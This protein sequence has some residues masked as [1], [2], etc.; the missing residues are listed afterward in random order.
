MADAWDE[1]TDC[2]SPLMVVNHV[3][4]PYEEKK[5]KTA[6]KEN[7]KPVS[8]KLS[9]SLISNEWSGNPSEEQGS[10]DDRTLTPSVWSNLDGVAI[11]FAFLHWQA[12][13]HY[14]GN[15]IELE[16]VSYCGRVGR[17][18]NLVDANRS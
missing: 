12:H 17:R 15:S 1:G 8:H 4:Y 11:A 14:V 2:K 10:R 5:N 7:R 16:C 6:R 3:I 9:N 13:W 18:S